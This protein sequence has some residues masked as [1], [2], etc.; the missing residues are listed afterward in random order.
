MT[1]APSPKHLE[2]RCPQCQ[3]PPTRVI[4]KDNRNSGH[5]NL[6]CAND[7]LWWYPPQGNATRG[8]PPAGPR[9]TPPI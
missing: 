8:A 1:N 7:H 3:Q 6:A 5:V 2:Q 4:A 9:R